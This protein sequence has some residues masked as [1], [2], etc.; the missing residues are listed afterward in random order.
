MGIGSFGTLSLSV[1][2][3]AV[4]DTVTV[5]NTGTGFWGAMAVTVGGVSAVTVTLIAHN[6]LSFVVPVGAI[7]GAVVVTNP[8]TGAGAAGTFTVSS[9]G[10]YNR[11]YRFGFG[12]GF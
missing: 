7:T 11:P 1:A 9:A 4:G 6:S 12:F 3:G 8:D 2:T 5:Y 10:A